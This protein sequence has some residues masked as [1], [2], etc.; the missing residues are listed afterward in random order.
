ML[1][2]GI[3]AAHP[4]VGGVGSDP[5]LLIDKDLNQIIDQGGN[6]IS[7][8][9]LPFPPSFS[10]MFIDH[11]EFHFTGPDTFSTEIITEEEFGIL[12]NTNFGSPK[13]DPLQP[14]GLQN[15]L[16][17]HGDNSGQS[18]INS[19][20]YDGLV[21]SGIDTGTL[22]A[23][24]KADFATDTRIFQFQGGI[25]SRLLEVS[26]HKPAS[27]WTIDIRGL[28]GVPNPNTVSPAITFPTNEYFI[29]A[30]NSPGVGSV[31]TAT[32]NG[33]SVGAFSFGNPTV[34]S[35]FHSAKLIDTG[36]QSK[37]GYTTAGDDVALL[38]MG[39]TTEILETSE[40]LEML[41]FATT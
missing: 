35:W 8:K 3:V 33:V 17:H 19:L 6:F 18:S 32:I 12:P 23:I 31:Y 13:V 27:N 20:E 10:A 4:V 39:V 9:G 21:S 16:L 14:T 1:V 37:Y 7:W 25:F 40:L 15:F 30:I 29:V 22:W 11:E 2:N 38:C 5:N 28:G 26:L 34:G 41:A 36:G 24:V